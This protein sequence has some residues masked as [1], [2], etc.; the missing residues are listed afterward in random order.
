M[1]N[2]SAFL[3]V[4]VLMFAAVVLSAC[5]GGTVAISD[6]PVYP[7]AAALVPG[8]DPVADTLLNNAEQ[9]A[10]LRGNL[11][12]GG[13]VEQK[14]FRLPAGT[15]WEQVKAYFDGEL[16]SAGWE[17]GLGGPGGDLANDILD[18]ANTGNDLF[19]TTFYSKGKQNLTVMRVA[20]ATNPDQ[21]YLILSLATN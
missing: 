11:G 3:L 18:S 15:T 2:R 6:L 19:Q 4:V 5:G 20:D 13:S 12:V 21:P 7:D 14:G 16:D 17:S 1:K 9:D 8:E 10:A